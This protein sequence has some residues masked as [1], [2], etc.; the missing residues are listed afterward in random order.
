MFPRGGHLKEEQFETCN[1]FASADIR[2]NDA[3]QDV[4]R[5]ESLA[6]FSFSF[7]TSIFVP[8]TWRDGLRAQTLH[9]TV[10]RHICV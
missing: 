9:S 5:L 10:I 3:C 8:S 2:I 7:F 1:D 4:F 6:L